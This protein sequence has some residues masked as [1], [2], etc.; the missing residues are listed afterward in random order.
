MGAISVTRSAERQPYSMMHMGM[1]AS[2][3]HLKAIAALLELEDPLAESIMVL[4]QSVLEMSVRV[5]WLADP[6]LGITQ[7]VARG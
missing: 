7:R 1:F 3:L 5:W 6:S 4:S 2:F